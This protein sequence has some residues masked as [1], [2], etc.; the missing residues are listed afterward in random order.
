MWQGMNQRRFPRLKS[1]C[2][3]KLHQEGVADTTISTTTEN[4]GLGGICVLLDR[5]MD[6]FSP[7]DLELHLEAGKPV[8]KTQGTIVW[9][10]LR[11]DNKKKPSFDTGIE[12]SGLLA[13]DRARLEALL[14]K[15]ESRPGR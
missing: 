12:F 10:V 15:T 6:I 11:R 3:V 7:V 14:D 9:V 1:P 2:V 4:I 5:G 13:D 8:L